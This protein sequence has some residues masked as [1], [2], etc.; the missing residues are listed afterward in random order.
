M[1]VFIS[2]TLA[3]TAY[4]AKLL[5]VTNHNFKTYFVMEVISLILFTSLTVYY[6]FSYFHTI[7]VS[8]IEKQRFKMILR[9][10][11]NKPLGCFPNTNLMSKQ[12]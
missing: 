4:G 9:Q 12:E 5:K 1:G 11:L 2:I 3:G 10:I 7:I 6:S 8:Q